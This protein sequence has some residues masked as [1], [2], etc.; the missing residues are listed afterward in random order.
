LFGHAPTKRGPTLA[1][2]RNRQHEASAI[3]TAL[4][5]QYRFSIFDV[6]PIICPAEI[7]LVEKN[8]HSL[9]KDDDHIS[10]YGAALL[11]DALAAAFPPF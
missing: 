7:C 4:A 10:L 2:Y 8:G 9:Y 5:S 11:A 1:A 3:V 6:T